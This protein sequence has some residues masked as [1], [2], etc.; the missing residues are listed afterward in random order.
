MRAKSRMSAVGAVVLLGATAA[1]WWGMSATSMGSS[2]P[3]AASS[4]PS[5]RHTMADGTVM[6]GSSMAPATRASARSSS[7]SDGHPSPAASMVCGDETARAVQRT[8]TMKALPHRTATWSDHVFR[9]TYALPAGKLTLTVADLSTAAP[10]RAWFD[11]LRKQLPAPVAI[12]GMAN[13]GFPAYE[14][15]RGDVVFFKDDKTLWVD[16][17]SVATSQLPPRYTRTGAAYQIA[18][19][20][21]ACWSE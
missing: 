19:A 10:G 4:M 20:V 8:F 21:I 9:C 6:S 12:T 3:M 5:D 13:L 17:S 15:Q 1:G 7:V 18:S 2:Q 11:S 16:A 14:T